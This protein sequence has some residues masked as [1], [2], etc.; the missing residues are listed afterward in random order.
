[1]AGRARFTTVLSRNAT[2]DTMIATNITLLVGAASR[3]FTCARQST[4]KAFAPL[5]Y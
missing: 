1:M 4:A 5:L 2:I 3:I